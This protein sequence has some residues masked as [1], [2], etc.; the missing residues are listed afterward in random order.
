MK[1]KQNFSLNLIV[2]RELITLASGSLGKLVCKPV[3]ERRLASGKA[4]NYYKVEVG[5]CSL[6]IAA[7]I[8]GAVM[9]FKLK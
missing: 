6:V 8:S 9:R 3:P 1:K 2:E 5:C 7:V 4:N